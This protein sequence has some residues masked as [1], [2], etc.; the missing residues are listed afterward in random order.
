MANGKERILPLDSFLFPRIFQAF[1]MSI[2]PT[3]LLIALCV[4][5]TICLTG[6]IMDVASQSVIVASNGTTEL[7]VYTWPITHPHAS[8]PPFRDTGLRT[9]VFATL[10][11]FASVH[12][13]SALSS[14]FQVNIEATIRNVVACF[15]SLV[16]AF[17][18]HIV[19]SLI[20]F[21]IALAI[22]SVGGG[23]IC[24]IAAL[25]FA[26]AERPGLR[27]AIR[28]G[29]RKFT[30]LFTA[31][32]TPM[33]AI[34]I[35]GATIV[36]LGAL[37]NI[38]FAGELAVG[39]LL[40]VAFAVAVLIA[41]V[42]IGL[43]GGFSLMF[44]TIAYEDSDCFDAMSR[45]FSYI[46]NKPWRMGFY[47]T[48]AFVY[49]AICYTF[50]RFFSFLV[51]WT[52]HTSLQLGFAQENAKLQAIWPEPTLGDFFGASVATTT[53]WST[54]VSSAFIYFWVLLVVGS[55]V[56]FV[57][58]FYFSASTIIYALMRNRVDLIALED[59]Y[60]YSPKETPEAGPSH[61]A[62]ETALSESESP[63]TPSSEKQES[64]Q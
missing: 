50:V 51:L 30:A 3:K 64:S 55:V 2:Q 40:P 58:S 45:S 4:L 19:Y 53:N 9:G 23:A 49:G 62:T 34:I 6:W 43:V 35:V 41:I 39:L 28:F 38:P 54:S 36:L 48:I 16:W 11:T 13:H 26:G 31:P 5:A 7:D 56:A 61:T 12:L 22:L 63:A 25:Q 46:Y 1:R 24:R 47:M 18:H 15:A 37:G 17:R 27:Q 20:F 8:T 32:L 10:W 29:L 52:T 33:L 60:V 14:L 42:A 21:A 59:V 44:P 57:I